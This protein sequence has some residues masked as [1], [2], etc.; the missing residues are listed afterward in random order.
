MNHNYLFQSFFYY[1]CGA[2][3]TNKKHTLEQG[4]MEQHWTKS[5][6]AA[7]SQSHSE[8][9]IQKREATSSNA[10]QDGNNNDNNNSYSCHNV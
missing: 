4:E 8:M 2:F 5:D 7:G 3:N 10:I 1:F 6:Q 9:L